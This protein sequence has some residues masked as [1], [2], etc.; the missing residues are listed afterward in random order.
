MYKDHFFHR[1]FLGFS[2]LIVIVLLTSC[3]SVDSR[4][5]RTSP[6]ST[7]LQS[8]STSTET[9]VRQESTINFT[10]SGGNAA[11][12]TL[13]TA[14][15]ISKLRHGHYEFTI[16]MTDTKYSIFIV[17][18]GYQGP[19]NYTLAKTVNGGDVHIS[20]GDTAPSWDLS[21]QPK[22]S[23]AMTVQ[24]DTPTSIAG[25]DRMQGTFTCPLLFSSNP[26]YPQPSV[27]VHNG[28][29]DIAIIVES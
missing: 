21:L 6:T 27:T 12:Y 14:S 16:D 9:K 22:A 24:S 18:Y 17:F 28:S 1:R 23:C 3:A 29:F 25:I 2:C 10:L 20:L 13:H 4:M 19:G 15:P 5:E 7:V 26:K 8:I 11:N